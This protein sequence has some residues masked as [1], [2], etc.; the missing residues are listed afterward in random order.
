MSFIS[1][2]SC[3]IFSFSHSSFRVLIFRGFTFPR[4]GFSFFS[5]YRRKGKGGGIKQKPYFALNSLGT[6]RD[7]TDL[8]QFQA[9][10]FSE[11]AKICHS[12]S[13]LL[14]APTSSQTKKMEQREQQ[15]TPPSFLSMTSG[16]QPGT[17]TS[18]AVRAP[19]PLINSALGLRVK[20]AKAH[21]RLAGVNARG[22]QPRF[23]CSDSS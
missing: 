9:S 3:P 6:G 5:F 4:F 10:T 12:F 15:K 7:G 11:R 17:T 18:G 8:Q 19:F 21:R 13:R 2:N 23:L 14:K 1:T 22:V 16:P 20:A